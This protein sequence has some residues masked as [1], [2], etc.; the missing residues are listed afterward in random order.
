MKPLLFLVLLCTGCGTHAT[1]WWVDGQNVAHHYVFPMAMDPER[2]S[3]GFGSRDQAIQ[4]LHEHG[5]KLCME[6]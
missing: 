1:C 4:Y 5:Q 2:E 3:V 6:N